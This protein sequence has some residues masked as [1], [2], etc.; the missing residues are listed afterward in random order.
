[1]QLSDIRTRVRYYLREATANVWLDAELTALVNLAQRYIASR[2]RPELIP[3]LIVL[4]TENISGSTSSWTLPTD[5]IE[6]VSSPYHISAAGAYTHLPLK[7]HEEFVKTSGFHQ[8]H[9]MYQKQESMLA[10]GKLY[11]QQTFS[12]G[13]LA[14]LYL[15]YPTDLSGDSDVS[16]V[17]DGYIDLVV[18]KASADALVKTR[19]IQESHTLLKSLEMRIEMANKENK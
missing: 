6:M 1:M 12:D 18:I 14:Y 5:Y 13:V 2:L 9:L 19:Q 8:T 16:G 7:S 11:V 3:G 15:K 17:P 4:K 10:D